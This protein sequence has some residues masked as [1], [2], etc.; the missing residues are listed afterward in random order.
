MRCNRCGRAMKGI[1]YYDGAC[2][3]GGLIEAAP[4]PAPSG[5]SAHAFAYFTL[6]QFGGKRADAIGYLMRRLQCL[7]AAGFPERAAFYRQ[8]VYILR[9][10]ANS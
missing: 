1:G 10:G 8:A 2:E 5:P 6:Q 4:R 9:L 3:C 7:Q